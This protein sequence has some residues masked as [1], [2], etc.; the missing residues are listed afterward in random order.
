ME[1][2]VEAHLDLAGEICAHVANGGSLIDLA[3]LWRVRYSDLVRWMRADKLREDA[4]KK[5]LID[6]DEW[7][8]QRILAE[9]KLLS[10][11]D[12]RK[13]YDAGGCLLPMREMPDDVAK[14][15]ISVES[16]NIT[17]G[18]DL[19]VIGYTT[20]VKISDKITS[21][22]LLGKQIGMFV[23]RHDLRVD[24]TLEDLVSGSYPDNSILTDPPKK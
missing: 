23:Q 11:V 4:Y 14:A 18:R 7:T 10:T 1:K 8:I 6:R 16:D 21:L 24:K 12:I 3:D 17:E 13:A 20:K 15:I 9:V 19:A 5:A 22:Q 2:L